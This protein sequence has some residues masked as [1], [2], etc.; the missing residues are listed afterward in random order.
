MSREDWV[1]NSTRE[2]RQSQPKEI[3]FGTYVSASGLKDPSLADIGLEDSRYCSLHHKS[4]DEALAWLI[5]NVD[6]SKILD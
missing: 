1:H 2:F 6:T 5:E 4:V 3:Y